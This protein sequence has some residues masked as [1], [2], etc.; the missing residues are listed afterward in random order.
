VLRIN[1][2]LVKSYI[3][4]L[5]GNISA[6]FVRPTY[7]LIIKILSQCITFLYTPLAIVFSILKIKFP[8]F[9]I[10]RIGHLMCE[11]DCFI[12][13]HLLKIEQ[14]PR[15]IMLAPTAM[16]ANQAAVRYWSRYFL[17][18]QNPICATLLR[19][20]QR[21]PL[22]RFRTFKYV[23]AAEQT[24]EIFQIYTK[25]GVGPALLTLDPCDIERGKDTLKLLGVP[26]DTWYVCLHAREGGYS[27]VDEHLHSYR[28]LSIA[29]FEKAVAYIASKGGVCIRMGDASMT[30]APK[31]QGLIDYA[32]SDFKQDWM[33]LFLA[34]NCVFFLGSNSGAYNMSSVFGRPSALVGVAP[35]SSLAIGVNDISIPMLYRSEESGQILNF[36]EIMQSRLAV[37]RATADFE[38]SRVSLVKNTPEDI[39]DLTIEQLERT[40]GTYMSATEDE[41][42]Q[43]R[44]KALL[45]SGHYCHGT[46]SRVGNRFLKKYQELLA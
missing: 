43:T 23:C 34:A 14:V 26:D 38:K 3:D 41:I 10:N 33:D 31:M 17:V 4:S 24:A 20:L 19:P 13:E 27:P 16:S 8:D 39:L 42:R 2:K 15:A 45:T 7:K 44:F 18:I 21:H 28:N 46:A 37:L 40:Q 36:K 12:K 6:R 29:D 9:L 1:L 32:L 25:W 11:P 22:T 5:P 35:L 30:P